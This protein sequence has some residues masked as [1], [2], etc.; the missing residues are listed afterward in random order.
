MKE[1][2][3][4]IFGEDDNNDSKNDSTQSNRHKYM[5]SRVGFLKNLSY[6]LAQK[7]EALRREN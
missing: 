5:S 6:K 3:D 7:Y 4:I 2:D 1:A